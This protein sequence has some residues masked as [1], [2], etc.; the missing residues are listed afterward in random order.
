MN[1]ENGVDKLTKICRENGYCWSI[2]YS[3]V[4]NLFY[5]EICDYLQ[6]P[7]LI[8]EVKRISR[9]DDL[10]EYLIKRIENI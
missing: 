7:S 2:S 3:E 10:V 6:R 8:H 4:E 5:G 1:Y 9:F